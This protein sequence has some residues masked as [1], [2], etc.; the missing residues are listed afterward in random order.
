MVC[1]GIKGF[2][3]FCVSTTWLFDG[4]VD[5]DVDLFRPYCRHSFYEP[6]SM[7][8]LTESPEAAWTECLARAREGMGLDTFNSWLAGARFAGFEYGTFTV[9]FK[10]DFSAGFVSAHFSDR[11]RGILAGLLECPDLHFRAISAPKSV[12]ST[13]RDALLPSMLRPSYTFE[14]FIVDDNNR[15]AYAT[16]M[17]AAKN[18]GSDLAN[19]LFIYGGVGLGKTHLI[20]A[21][22]H[23]VITHSPDL[24]VMYISSEEFVTRLVTALTTGNKSTMEVFESRFRDVHYLLMDDVQFLAGKDVSEHK[25]FHIFNNLYLQGRQIVLTSDRPP[26]EIEPLEERLVSRFQS[27]IVADIKPP[28]FETRVAILS[29]I[30]RERRIT[31]DEDTLYFIAESV[32]S[33]VRQL[34]G[35]VNLLSVRSQVLNM[36]ITRELVRTIIAE[37]LGAGTRHL[38]PGSIT[39]AV[40]EAFSINPALIRG[41][42]RKRDVLVPR[43]AAMMLIRE[44]TDTP[45]TEIGRFFSGRDHSTVLNSI[46]RIKEMVAEN[47]SL[48][49]KIQDIR[50]SLTS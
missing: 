38:N 37:Y 48:K 40:A 18:M 31:I 43:Q 20:Q 23:Y 12:P 33:N 35:V 15:L 16:A 19:P 3:F 8:S 45:L 22:A 21:V 44:L 25:L 1:P 24:A 34:E 41:K 7:S 42:Q 29:Q 28:G 30:T 4:G 6:G 36:S 32:K 27:G 11:L 14:R 9:E 13:R 2:T 46:A 17:S 47:P 10:D 26:H 5:N 49:R 39:G 50:E